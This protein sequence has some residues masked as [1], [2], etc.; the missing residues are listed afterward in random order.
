MICPVLA[1]YGAGRAWLPSNE[2]VKA[3]LTNDNPARRWGAFYDCFSERIRFAALGDWLEREVIASGTRGG[4][5]RPGLQVVRQAVLNCVPDANE[6]WYDPDRRQS[7][8]S[9]RGNAQ[10]FNNLSAGQ[11]MMLSMVA[12]IAI[13]AVTQNAHLLPNGEGSQVDSLVPQLLAQTPGIVLIDELDVHLHPK[14]QRRVATDLKRTFP[15][16]QFVC[17]SHSPQ[18][19]GELQPEEIRLLDEGGQ[20]PG[21]SFGMDSNWIL[22]VLMQGEDQDGEVK[23]LLEEVAHLIGN[24]EIDNASGKLSE[25]RGKM[26]NSDA[27]QRMAS[28]IE[29]IKVLG[30]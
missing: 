26:G 23:R 13:K 27:I 25:L 14:W 2:R 20:V 19:I 17:T 24:R 9:I 12:D 5:M 11:R 6:I 28:T 16:I 29:R 15:M 18:V 30:K 3:K 7:V 4:K 22:K 10:P 21:Q 8:L 1:Y